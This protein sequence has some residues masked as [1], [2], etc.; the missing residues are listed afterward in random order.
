MCGL[1][2][3]STDPQICMAVA[4]LSS[5][6]LSEKIFP[7]YSDSSTA[8]VQLGL[9]L[10]SKVFLPILAA[11]GVSFAA[12]ILIFAL[13]KLRIEKLHDRAKEHQR[14]RSIA[15]CF[16]ILSVILTFGAA[17]AV[18]MATSAM[19]LLNGGQSAQY[20][21][22][23]GKPLQILQW[24]TLALETLIAIGLE[25]LTRDSS[26]TSNSSAAKPSKQ[27]KSNPVS[28]IGF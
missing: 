14:L 26:V 16:L 28:A 23:Q 19:A 4:G 24:T 8:L 1:S 17:A 9:D 27:T 12:G 13:F 18:S 25:D 22:V 3:S 6:A 15:M 2:T 21:V 11:G 20:Q 10:S 7:N 5:S